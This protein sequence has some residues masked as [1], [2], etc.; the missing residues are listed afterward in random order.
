[1]RRPV[2]PNPT[3]KPT[4]EW[5][6]ATLVF[7]FP[8]LFEVRCKQTTFVYRKGTDPATAGGEVARRAGDNVL[9][10][11]PGLTARSWVHVRH[12]PERVSVFDWK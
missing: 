5:V 3:P 4:A 11:V 10:L 7:D 1:M 12:G 2:D 9:K 6:E 8:G